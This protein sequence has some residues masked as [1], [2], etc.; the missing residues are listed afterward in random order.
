MGCRC[1]TA[2]LDEK[3]DRLRRVAGFV[4][5]FLAAALHAAELG[6]AEGAVN[7]DRTK[8][9]LSY[10]YAIGKQKNEITNRRDDVKIILTDK[11][12]A[13]DANLNEIDFNFPEGVLGIVVHVTAN[14][15][16]IT[17]AV[18][19]HAGGTYDAGFS[20]GIN[21]F[22]FKP[23]PRTRGIISGHLS[24]SR[25][26]TNTMTFSLEADFNAIQH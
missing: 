15:Q 14:N 8:I 1:Y 18:V 26:Q 21:E 2:A 19:Q 6:R 22:R 4:L 9:D 12:I 3:E 20:E 5:L 17:H 11:P 24:A 23:G 13:P 7:V 16:R 25:I 10:A